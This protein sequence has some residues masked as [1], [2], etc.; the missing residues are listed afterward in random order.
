MK[1]KMIFAIAIVSL[2]LFLPAFSGNAAISPGDISNTN[3]S[4]EDVYNY[5]G[6][7][8]EILEQGPKSTTIFLNDTYQLD[9]T[10]NDTDLGVKATKL[11]TGGVSVEADEMLFDVNYKITPDGQDLSVTTP[12]F[13]ISL[14]SSG[15]N[16]DEWN[17]TVTGPPEQLDFSFNSTSGDMEI[18]DGLNKIN[19]D[20]DTVIINDG[21]GP[22]S[23]I[24]ERFNETA[25][26]IFCPTGI[27]FVNWNPSTGDMGVEYYIGGPGLIYFGPIMPPGIVWWDGVIFITVGFNGICI[28]WAGVTIYVHAFTFILIFDYIVITW[29]FGF[30]LYRIVILIWDIT[31]IIYLAL[32]EL[33]IVI[34]YYSFEIKIYETQVVIVYEYIEIVIVFISIYIWEFTFIFHF[35]FWFIEIFYIIDIN[36]NIIVQ[37]IRFIFIPVIVPVFIPIVFFVPVLI[38]QYIHIYVPYASPALHIDVSYEDLQM[39]THT[40]QYF[41]YDDSGNP[42]DDATVSVNYD[43]TDYPATFVIDGIYQVQLPASTESETI[44]VTATKSWYPDAI[45]V[46][47]LEVDWIIDTIT[48]PPETVT[49]PT[50]VTV[51]ETPTAPLYIVPILSALFLMA[52]GTV[53][54]SRKKKN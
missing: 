34:I 6:N 15:P 23:C 38:I 8:V 42:V 1:K 9:L 7:T 11:D 5:D 30:T 4:Q 37:P 28:E 45:L 21:V 48:P 47:D 2:I 13:E 17:G 10:H 27:I 35:E 50:N 53:L 29:Y 52:V 19:I 33:L 54:L 44:T 18:Y 36:I 12:D 40:I 24:I 32:I 26:T 46:Y 3:V 25:W 31:I 41:V 49:V 14:G 43:G 16:N 51:T 20:G 22:V 39:P